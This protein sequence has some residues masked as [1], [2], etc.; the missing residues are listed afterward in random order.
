MTSIVKHLHQLWF[1]GALIVALGLGAC[2]ASNQPGA[3]GPT[4]TD[5]AVAGQRVFQTYCVHCHTTDRTAKIGPGM[6][7]L[8]APGGPTL[9]NGVDY[10]GKLPNGAIISEESVAA[11]IREGGRGQIGSMPGIQVNDAD[12]SVLLAYLKTLQ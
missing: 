8:F 1:A 11:W 9:P 12:L 4:S 3:T 5:P 10:A 2:S 6:A 7:G